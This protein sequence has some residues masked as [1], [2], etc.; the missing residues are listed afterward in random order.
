[1]ESVG[2][3]TAAISPAGVLFHTTSPSVSS[4]QI[5][6]GS[7]K[8]RRRL[9]YIFWCIESKYLSVFSGQVV[10]EYYCFVLNHWIVYQPC[11]FW[12]TDLGIFSRCSVSAL[13]S[14]QGKALHQSKVLH[15]SSVSAGFLHHRSYCSFPMSSMITSVHQL[16][17]DKTQCYPL[18]LNRLTSR[19]WPFTHR[20][21]L[22]LVTWRVIMTKEVSVSNLVLQAIYLGN[23]SGNSYWSHASH[24]GTPNLRRTVRCIHVSS[25]WC[26]WSKRWSRWSNQ[27]I[28]S[29]H[30]P[31]EGTREEDGE[32]GHH[33]TSGHYS[34]HHGTKMLIT[35]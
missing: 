29:R 10:F 2:Q 9:G 20:L 31:L 11:L 26:H 32:L 27:T 28:R 30:R 22:K 17:R 35:F 33:Q 8:K 14:L 19:Q 15:T 3:V 23:L 4:W 24:H 21:P 1:M 18:T 12:L 5:S 25:A 7:E 6:W 16:E 34:N 13:L